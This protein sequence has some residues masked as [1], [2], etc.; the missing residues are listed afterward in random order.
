MSMPNSPSQ[1]VADDL[2]KE[3]PVISGGSQEYLMWKSSQLAGTNMAKS[4]PAV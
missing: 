2:Y 4:A 1:T 3:F